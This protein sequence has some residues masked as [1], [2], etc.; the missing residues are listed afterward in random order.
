MARLSGLNDF[1]KTRKC[2]FIINQYS[3]CPALAFSI[4]NL[5]GTLQ[6]QILA[7]KVY[8]LFA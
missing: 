5:L 6:L 4:T 7:R 3:A 8:K 2:N 1:F